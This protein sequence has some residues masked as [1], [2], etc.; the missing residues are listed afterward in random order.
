MLDYYDE[1][2]ALFDI[3]E[4]EERLSEKAICNKCKN[5]IK[6]HHFN[7]DFIYCIN[8]VVN[9]R[10][11]CFK[12]EI[13]LETGKVFDAMEYS[14]LI[15]NAKKSQ[16]KTEQLILYLKKVNDHRLIFASIYALK[17]EYLINLGIIENNKWTK[18][19]SK[20][21]FRD[22]LFISTNDENNYQLCIKTAEK[23]GLKYIKLPYMQFWLDM[24]GL[25]W[26]IEKADPK[27]GYIKV[28]TIKVAF[29]ITP[30]IYFERGEKKYYD[31][32]GSKNLNKYLKLIDQKMLEIVKEKYKNSVEPTRMWGYSLLFNVL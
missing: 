9:D 23:I 25:L 11:Y 32:L 19:H 28:N 1:I 29:G 6:K 4:N 18:A 13:D 5:L 14:F 10:G 31:A 2:S 15:T 20:N 21:N 8:D 12:F 3:Y 22:L 30:R 27:K 16:K 17:V 24:E 7:R 26:T